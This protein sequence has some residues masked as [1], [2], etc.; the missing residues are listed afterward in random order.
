MSE[1]HL[2]NIAGHAL[3]GCASAVAQ[4]GRCGPGALSAAAGSF[5]GPILKDLGFQRNL[6]GKTLYRFGKGTPQS[7]GYLALNSNPFPSNGVSKE[8]PYWVSMSSAD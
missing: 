2:F 4:G 1:A 6:L 8:R 5:A 3:V 7:L